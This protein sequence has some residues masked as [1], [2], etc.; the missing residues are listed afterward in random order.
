MK[1]IT[2]PSYYFMQMFQWAK[3]GTLFN[4]FWER[5][6]QHV[7]ET[8]DDDFKVMEEAVLTG[9]NCIQYPYQNYS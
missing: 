9:S 3:P 6:L 5:D 8:F 1:L 2:M 4:K 7:Y